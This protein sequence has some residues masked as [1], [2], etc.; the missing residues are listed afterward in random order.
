[1]FTG[2]QSTINNQAIPD[3]SIVEKRVIALAALIGLSLGIPA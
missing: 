3:H 2:A 1:V